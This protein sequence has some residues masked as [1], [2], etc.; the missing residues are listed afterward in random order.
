MRCVDTNC[1]CSGIGRFKFGGLVRD[2]H[3]CTYLTQTKIQFGSWQVNP[4]LPK[5]EKV[6]AEFSNFTV[7]SF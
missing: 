5:L 1:H 4:P 7:V 3:K 2:H 6:Q